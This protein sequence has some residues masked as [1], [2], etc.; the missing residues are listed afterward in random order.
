MQTE[1][2]CYIFV[3]KQFLEFGCKLAGIVLHWLRIEYERGA[4]GAG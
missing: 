4:C 1:R 3:K 2:K